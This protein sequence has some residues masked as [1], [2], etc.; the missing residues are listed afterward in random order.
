MY[1]MAELMCDYVLYAVPRCFDEPPVQ[2]YHAPC[3]VT[4]PPAGGHGAYLYLGHCNAVFHKFLVCF[5]D[6][7]KEYLFA[8]LVVPAVRKLLYALSIARV[9]DVDLELL[10]AKLRILAA[11]GYKR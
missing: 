3:V 8:L 6:Y 1:K 5:K 9:P 11:V 10:S 7:F 2:R 4:A